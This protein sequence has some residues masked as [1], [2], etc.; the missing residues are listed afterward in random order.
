MLVDWGTD[1]QTDE[2]SDNGTLCQ[3]R[4]NTPE[5]GKLNS[6]L[7]TVYRPHHTIMVIYRPHHK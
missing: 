3:E 2:L 7:Q 5:D 4:M 6:S 1:R